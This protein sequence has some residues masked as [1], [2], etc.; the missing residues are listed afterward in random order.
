MAVR[1]SKNRTRQS[2]ANDF[3][4]SSPDTRSHPP[5]QFATSS[6]P[7][8]RSPC[9]PARQ[10]ARHSRASRVRTHPVCRYCRSNC[11]SPS[12]A[13]RRWRGRGRAVRVD[14]R[15]ASVHFYQDGDDGRFEEGAGGQCG[16]QQLLVLDGDAAHG[17]TGAAVHGD[18]VQHATVGSGV[19]AGGQPHRRAHRY[20]ALALYLEAFAVW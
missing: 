15:R 18:V 19:V 3:A 5:E 17:F 14:C 16:Q 10:R 1:N 20:P 8:P 7:L 9:T 6:C 2:Q 11:R 12:K 13:R 4:L